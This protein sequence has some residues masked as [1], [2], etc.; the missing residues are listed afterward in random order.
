LR[1]LNLVTVRS[2]DKQT[3]S[4]IKSHNLWLFFIPGYQAKSL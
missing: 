4:P 2:S 3:A 1:S